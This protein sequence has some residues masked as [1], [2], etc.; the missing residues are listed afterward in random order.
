[1]PL[2]QQAYDGR[3]RLTC[4]YHLPPVHLQ[5]YFGRL[6]GYS[7]GLNVFQVL[8]FLASLSKGRIYY[9]HM[10][11]VYKGSSDQALVVQKVVIY[12]AMF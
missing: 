2:D 7:T 3:G 8:V 5:H 9:C 4:A 6:V 10:R 12:R 1:M 11:P